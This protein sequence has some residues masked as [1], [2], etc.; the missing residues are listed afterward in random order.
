PDALT[1]R[2]RLRAV[3]AAAAVV[4]DRPHLPADGRHVPQLRRQDRRGCEDH[5][6]DH[7]T[8]H[9]RADLHVPAARPGA[10]DP[11]RHARRSQDPHGDTALRPGQVSAADSRLQ[12]D[13]GAALQPLTLDAVVIGSGPNGLAAALTLARAGR[14]VRGVDAE[15]TIAG[16]AAHSMVPLDYAS[17]AGYALGLI[18]AA[19]AAGWPVARGGSQQVANALA[20]HLRTLGGDIVTSTRVEALSQ[21][22]PSRAVLC[23]V[24]PRQ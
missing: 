20:A 5:R 8:E 3:A 9:A 11:R 1:A 24:T 6:A 19:H 14:S 7:R 10:P 21:L 23:D 2:H 17:T 22:P 4:G 16:A 13:P 18:V 15:S 12:L